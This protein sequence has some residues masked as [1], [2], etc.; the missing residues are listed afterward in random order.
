[1]M[2]FNAFSV[3]VMILVCGVVSSVLREVVVTVVAPLFAAHL[4]GLLAGVAK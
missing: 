4:R 1:M 3:W 2:A